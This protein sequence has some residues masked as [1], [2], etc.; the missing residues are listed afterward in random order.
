VAQ[1]KG[2]GARVLDSPTPQT[3][4]EKPTQV[5]ARLLHFWKVWQALGADPWVINVLK[6]GYNLEFHTQP[7]LSRVPLIESSVQNVDRMFLLQEHINSM[8]D[9]EAIELVLDPNSTGFYS[10]LFLIPKKTGTLRPVVDLSALN[11]YITDQ[12]FRMESAESVR[13]CLTQGTWTFSIDLTDAYFH[14]PIHPASRK[15]LRICFK[16][17]IYQFRALPFGLKPAPWLFTTIFREVRVMALARDIPIHLYLDDW[18]GKAIS[19]QVCLLRAQKMVAL[20]NLLGLLINYLKSDL[21]PKQIFDFVGIHYDLIKF[22][23]TPTT[24]NI[25]KVQSSVSRITKSQ[26][27]PAQTW[28]SIIGLI[29]SQDKLVPLGRLHVRPFQWHLATR[30]NQVTGNPLDRVQTSPQIQLAAQW[31]LDHNNLIQGVPLIPPAPTLRLFTDASVDGWGAHVGDLTLQGPWTIQ[32]KALHINVLEMRAVT[33]A[34]TAVDTSPGDHVMV[35]SDNITVVAYIKHQGGTKS[36]TLWKETQPLFQLAID[37]QITLSAVH[38]PGHLNVIADQLSRRGQILPT[39]WSLNPTVVQAL[40]RTWGTPQ[41]DLFATRFNNKCPQ[42]VSPVP[43]PLA[44]AT[45]AMSLSWEGMWGYAYPPHQ[46]MSKVLAKLRQY[47]CQIIMIAPKWPKQPWLSELMDLSIKIPYRLPLLP[48][49]LKQPGMEVFHSQPE[50]LNLHA[51]L[52]RGNPYSKEDIPQIQ[53][54]ELS[55]HREPLHSQ[56]MKGSGEFLLP[57]VPPEI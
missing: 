50:V 17:K 57:G 54:K 37:R 49:L 35:S 34:L 12:P 29:S 9:K 56:F 33:L 40:F 43:D 27:L 55:P 14:V 3:L 13:L 51:W 28:Q 21:V 36:R 25:S 6:L 16:G 24:Q 47:H 19:S 1:R 10:R 44:L 4:L 53:L 22:I 45:D 20:C 30:W 7:P 32:E 18:L 8:L 38:I 15:F 23:V 2:E 5:G 52:L 31:W 11:F 46:I 48:E 26:S 39:E 42:F 41:I